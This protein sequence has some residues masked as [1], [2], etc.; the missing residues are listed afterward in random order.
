M[1]AQEQYKVKHR[2]LKSY[3]RTKCTKG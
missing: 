1:N 3:K 2:K